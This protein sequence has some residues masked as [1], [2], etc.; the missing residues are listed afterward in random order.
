MIPDEELKVQGVRALIAAL[1]DVG[2]ERFVS[3]LTRA[4]FDYTKW[5][6][7]LWPEVGVEELS[8]KAMQMRSATKHGND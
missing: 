3:L 7:S 6:V 8:R 4:P 5:Q 2:A 1:G